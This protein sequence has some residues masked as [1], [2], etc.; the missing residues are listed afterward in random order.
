M[1]CLLQILS[2]EARAVSIESQVQIANIANACPNGQGSAA[3]LSPSLSFPLTGTLC[4]VQP[5]CSPELSITKRGTPDPVAPGATLLYTIT[6]A[7]TGPRSAKKVFVSDI[8]PE[9]TH[10]ASASRQPEIK[11]N[12]L[13]WDIGRLCGGT[14]D[15]IS[16]RVTVTAPLTDNWPLTNVVYLEAEDQEP[17]SATLLTRVRA[18]PLPELEICKSDDPDPVVAGEVLTYRIAYSVAGTVPATGVM[19]TD[20][21]PVEV[22]YL[23]ASPPPTHS[24]G[25]L[26]WALG[27]LAP[28]TSGVIEVTTA[29][30]DGLAP[31]S[32]LTNTATI[33][34]KETLPVTDLETTTVVSRPVFVLSKTDEPDP[35]APGAMLT[36]TISYRHV[37]PSPVAAVSI[38]TQ[39]R[40]N[41]SRGRTPS[42][43]RVTM[44]LP[45]RASR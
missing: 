5:N 29:V 6:Y 33:D 10:F 43:S 23:S 35:V 20:V 25:T 21:L 41:D 42:F 30:S 18:Q 22:T 40:T 28:R 37:G 34:S 39:L 45:W 8:L 26:V 3:P 13:T 14:S 17:I 12:V 36:Y 4:G 32:I 16:V 1:A 15:S 7:N 27:D 11:G 24:K 44:R 2:Q 19:I 31:G 9:E 38:T